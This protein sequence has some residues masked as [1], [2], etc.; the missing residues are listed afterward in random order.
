MFD[1][2]RIRER[3]TTIVIIAMEFIPF[4][5]MQLLIAPKSQGIE[6][7]QLICLQCSRPTGICLLAVMQFISYSSTTATY[8]IPRKQF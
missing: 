1:L 8:L 3:F 7:V 2:P 6:H 5:A 4:F